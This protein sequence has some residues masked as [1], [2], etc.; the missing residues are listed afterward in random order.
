MLATEP[1]QKLLPGDATISG[2]IYTVNISMD[3]TVC[4]SILY[5]L[6]CLQDTELDGPEIESRW[7]RDFPHMSRPSLGPIQPPVKSIPG[8]SQG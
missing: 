5:L 2:T 8:P 1:N 6:H 7:G 4:R 3:F